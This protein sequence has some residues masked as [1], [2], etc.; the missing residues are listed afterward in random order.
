[1]CVYVCFCVIWARLF[2][3]LIAI[4]SLMRFFFKNFF[5]FFKK[6]KEFARD[7]F[8]ILVKVMIYIYDEIFF[9]FFIGRR[10]F[11][12]DLALKK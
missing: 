11:I 12:I 8:E 3:I 5:I 1:M 9:F 10:F 7:H 4:C 2:E 6:K